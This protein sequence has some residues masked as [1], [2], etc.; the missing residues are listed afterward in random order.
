MF[1]PAC[2]IEAVEIVKTRGRGDRFLTSG[3]VLLGVPILTALLFLAL[4]RMGE[5]GLILWLAFFGWMIIPAS[6]SLA[7][8]L[9]AAFEARSL[10]SAVGG[11]SRSRLPDIAEAPGRLP[12][13]EET[14]RRLDTHEIG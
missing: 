7:V 5:T 14:T 13:A 4:G 1:C 6:L 10:R 11:P 3:A 8:G 9:G 2:R 12:A